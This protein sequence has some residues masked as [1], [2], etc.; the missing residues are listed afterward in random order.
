MG[1]KLYMFLL[2]PTL[3][4]QID[5]PRTSRIRKR[6]L[7]RRI[8]EL[9]ICVALIV[10]I[11]QQFINPLL[12]NARQPFR[13]LKLVRLLERVLKLAIPNL[14]VWL[15]L[16][17]A[18]FHCW[19]NIIAELTYFGDRLFYKSWWNATRLDVYWRHWNLPVHNWLVR[20]FFFPLLK[21]G[22]PKKV[23]AMSVFVF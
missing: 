14:L 22:A 11:T 17:Y 13:E 1:G 2:F 6:W 19:L 16:F 8:L 4:Y 12:M 3:C 18:L 9:L 23:A 15:C 7:L 10:V 5:Y 20:H 21:I